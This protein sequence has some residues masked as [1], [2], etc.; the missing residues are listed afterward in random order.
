[1]G[2]FSGEIPAPGTNRSCTD[3][4]EGLQGGIREVGPDRIIATAGLPAARARTHL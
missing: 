1:M 4:S 2:T 3:G